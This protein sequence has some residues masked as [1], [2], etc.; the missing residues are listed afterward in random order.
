M[1]VDNKFWLF[2][3]IGIFKFPNQMKMQLTKW[4]QSK[5]LISVRVLTTMT[6][7][8]LQIL[9]LWLTWRCV[10]KVR[11]LTEIW[12]ADTNIV[13]C[14]ASCLPTVIICLEDGV[15]R[16]RFRQNAY[17]LPCQLWQEGLYNLYAHIVDFRNC[18]PLCSRAVLVRKRRVSICLFW[19]SS[20]IFVGLVR[21]WISSVF[22]AIQLLELSL[23]S[24][25]THL[26]G[27]KFLYK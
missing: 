24:F 26:S 17:C 22:D 27:K 12:H 19:F 21:R 4:W 6:K 10:W 7:E 18:D 9:W 13:S 5:K 25:P 3:L 23:I 2:G 14:T 15:L 20:R 11:K 8:S 1:R 16:S